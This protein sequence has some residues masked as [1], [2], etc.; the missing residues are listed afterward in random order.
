MLQK[1]G[2]AAAGA[3]TMAPLVLLLHIGTVNG[4]IWW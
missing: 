4:V 1:S 3:A 2:A